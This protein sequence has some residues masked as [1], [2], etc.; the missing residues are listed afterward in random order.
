MAIQWTTGFLA[1]LKGRGRSYSIHERRR[2]GRLSGKCQ[3]NLPEGL[4]AIG[5]EFSV[6]HRVLDVLVQ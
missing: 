3:I 4:E 1:W 5:R 2:M 6:G